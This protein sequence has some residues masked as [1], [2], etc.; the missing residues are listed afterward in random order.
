V[1][2]TFDLGPSLGSV[3]LEAGAKRNQQ[4]FFRTSTFTDTDTWYAS[5]AWRPFG[6]SL[7]TLRFD[8]YHS[9]H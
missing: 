4:E 6:D 2:R 1:G 7:T 5:A 8:Y 9:D 3:A